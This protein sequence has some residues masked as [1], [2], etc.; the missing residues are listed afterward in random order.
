MASLLSSFDSTTPASSSQSWSHDVYISFRGVD[1]RKTFVSHLYSALVEQEVNTYLDEQSSLPKG[2][3]FAPMLSKAV[4]ESR[5]VLVVLSKNYAKSTW[6]LQELVHIMKCKEERGKIVMP[7]FYD[8]DPSEVRNQKKDY[9]EALGI[10]ESNNKNIESWRKA[11][12]D[13]TKLFGWEAKHAED[14]NEAKLVKDIV[15][16][17]SHQLFYHK[18]RVEMGTNHLKIPHEDIRLLAASSSSSHFI[19]P[20]SS[21]LSSH[22][23]FVSFSGADTCKAFVDHLHSALERKRIHTYK[24]EE[25]YHWITDVTPSLLKVIEESRIALIIFSEKYA[26]S[27]RCLDELAHIMKCKDEKG[28]IVIPIYYQV[29]PSEVRNQT[30]K[31]GAAFAKHEAHKNIESWRKAHVDIS[32]LVGWDTN[33][34]EAKLVNDIVDT[35]SYELFSNKDLVQTGTGHLKIS[36]KEILVATNTFA[37]ANIIARSGFGKVYRGQSAQHG[38]V[39]IKQLDRIHGQGDR[40]FTME[41]ALLSICKHENIASL[42]GFCD[43]NGEKILVYRYERNGSLDRHLRSKNLT[44]KHRLRICLGVAFGLK[45]LHDD[46][47]PH[48]RVIHRDMKSA[49]ILLDENWKPKIS[50]FGLS[51]IALANVPLSALVSNPCGTLGYVDPQYVEHSTLTQK[52]DVYSFG[53]VLFEVL[54]G[55]KV[56]VDENPDENHFSVKMA[57]NHYEEKTLHEMIDADFRS[58]MK[59]PSLSTFSSIAYECLKEHGEERPKMIQV[60]EKLVKALNYQQDV[61]AVEVPN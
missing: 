57:R 51:K 47:G 52:S 53:V 15:Y 6:C 5:I 55:R 60:I 7:I 3:A 56:T 17:V 59:S 13:V 39:A 34:N 61:A 43:E 54:F 1:T 31:Y 23:V 14:G 27:S 18:A 20:S 29:Y 35:I 48:H 16:T 32:D 25:P 33:G 37:E 49:N 28:Q 44:W 26:L 36:L 12:K 41:I 24:D 40:E 58:Q 46:I 22:Y 4:E 19:P 21:R 30:G 11:L 38:L 2:K 9:G 45:Y 50:D 42:V 10:H 8:V